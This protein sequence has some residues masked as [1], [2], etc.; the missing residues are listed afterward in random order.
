LGDDIEAERSEDI[1]VTAIETLN[2][3]EDFDTG[4][5]LNR[6]IDRLNQW[7][8]DQK[9][10]PD[11]KIDPMA[12]ALTDSIGSL[13]EPIQ[14]IAR[15]FAKPSD[16]LTLKDLVTQFENLSGRLKA[17]TAQLES[18]NQRTDLQ[19]IGP[20]STRLR[21][22]VSQLGGSSQLRG[23]E[24]VDF[25][26]RQLAEMSDDQKKELGLNVLVSQLADQ[27]K[28][29]SFIEVD[30]LDGAL[31]KLVVSMDAQTHLL[32]EIAQR[33]ESD[34]L[35]ALADE[36]AVIGQSLRSAAE[37][38]KLDDLT[39]AVRQVQ[40][41]AGVERLDKEAQRRDY[42]S[43]ETIGMQLNDP[44]DELSEVATQAEK[45]AIELGVEQ[46]LLFAANL[47]GLSQ[48]GTEIGEQIRAL[49][50]AS[51]GSNY[52]EELHDLAGQM[53]SLHSLV[54]GLVKPLEYL[55][56]LD[57][58]RFRQADG[59]VLQEAIWLRDI[60]R[61]VVGEERD[62]IKQAALLFD[63]TVRNIQVEIPSESDEERVM[64]TA[65]EALL[66]GHAT[67]DER[68]WIFVLLCRQLGI[69]AVQLAC[70]TEDRTRLQP[71][72]LGVLDKGELYLFDPKLGLPIPCPDGVSFDQGHLKVK[73][74]T[75]G[76]VVADDS[77]L[78]KLDMD[79]D[80]RYPIS[81]RDLDEVVAL[82]EA[83]PGYLA[84]RMELIEQRLVGKDRI[85]LTSAPT[86]QAERIKNCPHVSRIVV[87]SLP[88]ETFLQLIRLG[89]RRQ[90]AMRG[91]LAPFLKFP[92]LGKGRILHLKGEF[93]A[94]P[95]PSE[96]YQMARTPDRELNKPGMD[97]DDRAISV[98]A[99]Q[100]ASYWLGL[101]AAYRDNPASALDYLVNRVLRDSSGSV[102]A[103]GAVYNAARVFEAEGQVQQA[104]Q[105]Y[106][107]DTLSPD[108]HGNI[109]RARW[110]ASAAGGQYETP[111]GGADAGDEPALPPLA[112]PPEKKDDDDSLV[113]PGL[114]PPE[115][116]E[117]SDES[118]PP[119]EAPQAAPTADES[120]PTPDE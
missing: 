74:A 59:P 19:S 96:F 81:A 76:Q 57:K 90:A 88:Y 120:E 50:K 43:L 69:D 27:S 60:A 65:W 66:M 25:L 21:G 101:I 17:A 13:A 3:L 98:L 51:D 80:E 117:Q 95:G 78:R 16:A 37:S 22:F 23:S 105:H 82:V 6:T 41:F 47:R 108:Y 102:W 30:E 12:A 97:P 31:Q 53:S 116:E 115:D 77:L 94:N 11:W 79:D 100:N 104:I 107:M 5:M 45:L 103:F 85:V 70:Y 33:R 14:E 110:L 2:R 63:W 114:T 29:D 7:I 36:L 1:F 24:V 20:F 64:L 58:L 112:K 72:A 93:D 113:L 71:W 91:Y 111:V 86:S 119:L 44:S 18:L 109:L 34:A 75:L 118:L 99:K 10:P 46:L 54:A 52:N 62:A 84:Q 38:R 56:G 8:R 83:S 48:A 61:W 55:A 87:W 28:V 89:A 106:A 73:P 68:A 40:E 32:G 9:S 67:A 49:A 92:M 15:A 35:A 39:K 42:Q 26:S 4:E